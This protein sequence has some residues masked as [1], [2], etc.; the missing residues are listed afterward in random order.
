MAI[1]ESMIFDSKVVLLLG[2]I[3]YQ[4]WYLL[5]R[6]KEACGMRMR[7]NFFILSCICL[8]IFMFH[9]FCAA[10]FGTQR[11]LWSNGEKNFME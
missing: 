1:L 3:A 8:G 2:C 11:G 10:I 4:M 9:G 5:D 6:P 7:R